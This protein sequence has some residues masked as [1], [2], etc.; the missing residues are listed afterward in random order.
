[1]LTSALNY[2]ITGQTRMTG[3]LETSPANYSGHE[4]SASCVVMAVVNTSA[5][6]VHI[7]T[8]IS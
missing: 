5:T 1:M 4:V 3:T 8:R 6:L 2:S 7:C